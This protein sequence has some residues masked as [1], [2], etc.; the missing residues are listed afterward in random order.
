VTRSINA[1]ANAAHRSRQDS[2]FKDRIFPPLFARPTTQLLVN[3]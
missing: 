2:I 1:T 3:S